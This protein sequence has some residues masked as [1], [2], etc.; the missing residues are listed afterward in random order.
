METRIRSREKNA[1][2]REHGTSIDRLSKHAEV[3][4][5]IVKSIHGCQEFYER[6]APAV[7]TL[8]TASR[9]QREKVIR[10]RIMLCTAGWASCFI[11]SCIVSLVAYAPTKKIIVREITCVGGQVRV[12]F[13]RGQRQI[14][15]LG[16]PVCRPSGV[17]NPAPSTRLIPLLGVRP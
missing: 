2:V 16:D 7:S 3:L 11:R 13:R 4:C 17:E 6:R 10:L 14:D 1:F 5:C 8:W 9:L 12:T 15:I